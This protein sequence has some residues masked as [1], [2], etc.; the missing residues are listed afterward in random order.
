MLKYIAL[1]AAVCGL[2]AAPVLAAE[3]QDA[4][5]PEKLT[6]HELD[7]V[8]GGELLSLGI[9]APV[10]LHIEPISVNIPVTAATV[11]QANVAGTASFQGMALGTQNNFFLPLP[12]LF[13][14]G[15]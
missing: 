4:S 2:G 13:T 12:A 8:K 1:F 11:I 9:L 3:Q 10:N 5:K 7:Q 6:D 14:P 15:G